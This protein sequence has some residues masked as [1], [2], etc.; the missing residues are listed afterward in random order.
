M[1]FLCPS[2]EL[3]VS[4][5]SSDESSSTYSW[6]QRFAE[7]CV[8]G[9][10]PQANHIVEFGVQAQSII[11]AGASVGAVGCVHALDQDGVF[12]QK[13]VWSDASG[14]ACLLY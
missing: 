10:V 9:L 7:L 3:F 6:C 11:P 13:V 2:T 4:P 5:R 8:Q 12:G 14:C 1:W